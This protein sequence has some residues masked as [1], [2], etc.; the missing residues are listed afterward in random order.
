[1]YDVDVPFRRQKSERTFKRLKNL[2]NKL[3]QNF[4]SSKYFWPKKNLCTL[5]LERISS[6]FPCAPRQSAAKESMQKKFTQFQLKVS[7]FWAQICAKCWSSIC[8]RTE[9]KTRDRGQYIETG[10][11]LMSTLKMEYEA[12]Q[13]STGV[14]FSHSGSFG[15]V[16]RWKGIVL[17]GR[18]ASLDRQW[19]TANTIKS[20]SSIMHLINSLK[21]LRVNMMKVTPFSHSSSRSTWVL[22]LH[23]IA[24]VPWKIRIASRNHRIASLSEGLAGSNSIVLPRIFPTGTGN[25]GEEGLW[26]NYSF[27]KQNNVRF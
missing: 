7:Q 6:L 4:I 17:S 24:S 15:M 23:V 10:K 13:T 22:G 20:E 26:K 1:M 25:Q 3:H 9:V 12:P 19:L 2:I 27:N 21:I 14:L 8:R 16:I 18:V 11:E 5:S